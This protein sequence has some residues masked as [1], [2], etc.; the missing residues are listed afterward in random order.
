MAFLSECQ[1]APAACNRIIGCGS[2]EFVSVDFRLCAAG[3]AG[4]SMTFCNREMF[5]LS[6]S[7]AEVSLCQIHV[8]QPRNLLFHL[9]DRKLPV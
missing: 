1:V 3:S 9:R 7:Q 8:T 5:F 2:I 4:S 6:C